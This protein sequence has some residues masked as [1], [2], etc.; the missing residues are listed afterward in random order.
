MAHPAV[1]LRHG[2]V[3]NILHVGLP[4]RYWPCC[5]FFGVVQLEIGINTEDVSFV[6]LVA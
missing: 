1:L 2:C 4:S 3:G 5:N 6:Y